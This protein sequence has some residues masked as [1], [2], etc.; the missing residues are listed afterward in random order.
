[1]REWCS[2][3]KGN[4]TRHDFLPVTAAVPPARAVRSHTL[5][6]GPAYVQSLRP[7]AAADEHPP[8][9]LTTLS[10]D[11]TRGDGFWR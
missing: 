6:V 1:M 9:W 8:S 4:P 7:K 10:L 2:V 5:P 11:I 3:S